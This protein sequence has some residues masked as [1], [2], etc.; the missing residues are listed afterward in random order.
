MIDTSAMMSMLLNEP[1]KEAIEQ[2]LTGETWVA[3]ASLPYEVGNALSR[4][5]RRGWIHT[6]DAMAVM[7][8]FL[9]ILPEIELSEVPFTAAMELSGRFGIYGYDAF[10]LAAAERTGER[11][12]TLDGPMAAVAARMG[13]EVAELP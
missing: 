7:A 13:L 2:A 8:E 4:S 10:V 9:E 5:L 11:L 3:P 12:L 6:E 1:T